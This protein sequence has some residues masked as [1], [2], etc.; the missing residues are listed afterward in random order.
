M[1]P[2]ALNI[3]LALVILMVSAL[4]VPVLPGVQ[5]QS[6]GDS[7]RAAQLLAQSLGLR[8]DDLFVT[9]QV[10]ETLLDGTEVEIIKAVNLPSSEIV[11]AAFE[12]G[13]SIDLQQRKAQAGAAWRAQYGA[14]PPQTLAAL[15]MLRAE[16]K[17]NVAVWLF[18]EIEEMPRPEINPSQPQPSNDN[19]EFAMEQPARI[20]GSTEFPLAAAEVPWDIRQRALAQPAAGSTDTAAE[21]TAEQVA[22]GRSAQVEEYTRSLDA[23]APEDFAQRNLDH[24]RAQ[25]VPLQERFAAQLADLGLQ[26]DF[27]SQIAPEVVINGLTRAQVEKLAFLP[28]VNAIYLVPETAGPALANSRP[29]QNMTL[30]NDAG[31]DGSGVNVAVVEGE[32]ASSSNPYLTIA[33]FFNNTKP[34]MPHPTGVGG[35][36]RSTNAT[37][38]GLASG[39]TLYNANGS[40]D[41]A[42]FNVMMDALDWGSSQANAL[43]NSWYW[44]YPDNP[45]FWSVDR[46][47]DYLVRYGFDFLAVAAGNFGNGCS[48][49]FSSY[50]TSPAK[51][52][53]V[54]SVGN[55]EDNGTLG[56]S[57][58]VMDTCSSF[59]N[60]ATDTAGQLHDKP[61]VAAVGAS[62]TSTTTANPWIDNI[63]S[64]TSYSSPM[65]TSLAADIM[66][67]KPG[68]KL[69]PE[70]IRSIIMAS[71]LHNIEGNE[72]LS[73]K[74]GVGAIDGTA[75][76]ALAERDNFSNNLVNDSTTFPLDFY[77][78]AHKGERVRFV[79]NWLSNPTADYTSDPLQVDLDLSAYQAD[80]TFIESSTSVYNN[81]EIVD[82]IAP[83]TETYKF[84]VTRFSY[85]AGKT[86]YYGTAVWRGTYRISPDVSYSDP[87][88]TPLGT[89]LSIYG[90]DWPVTNNW[91]VTAILPINSDHDLTAYSASLFDDP[92]A[93][94]VLGE[95]Y[96]GSGMVDFVVV[97]GNHHAASTPEHYVVTKYTGTGGYKVNWSD[98]GISISSGGWYGPYTMA[99]GKVATIFDVSFPYGRTRR[100]TLV[101]TAGSTGADPAMAL[102]RSNWFVEGSWVQD[103]GDEVVAADD[104]GIGTTSEKLQYTYMPGFFDFGTS[105]WTGL[106]VMNKQVSSLTFYLLVEDLVF[107]PMIRR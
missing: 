96:F 1:S 77:Q 102:F 68:L 21:K 81:F 86:S 38:H 46:H 50:V 43:N 61:E 91:H 56:W 33:G 99:S 6:G 72:Q 49:N 60:P 37:N 104:F 73:D 93:R 69:Y 44:D 19:S 26:A 48:S 18:A 88:A 34:V 52:F 13:R 7:A 14:L 74:D 3:G 80:N 51:G 78:F 70:V 65:V 92:A 57:D 36:I 101:P 84:R 90:S 11:G 103:H 22:D 25:I 29:S 62:I 79:I 67:A 9:E 95:S 87:A 59:G 12:Q 20:A 28:M 39:V 100:I 71:A 58:D 41:G 40:Y 15:S 106:V 35:I 31:Y 8:S 89:H 66:E 55:Y 97:D 23:Q 94:S 64:G 17:V 105:D 2:K 5:A 76:L 32:R 53:N 16:E 85:V 27:A 82:F 63:G 47:M 54:L 83:A 30:V 107:L 98:P 24:L 75:A 42:E 4:N 45:T 10:Q